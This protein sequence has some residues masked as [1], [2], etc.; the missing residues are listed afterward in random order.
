MLI[1][2]GIVHTM[3]GPVI[4]NGYVEV[5]GRKIKAVGPMSDL[6]A[7]RSAPVFDAEGGH[8]IPG[9][10]D[11][12]CHLGMFGNGLGFE[13]DDGNESTDPCT[14]QLRAVDAINPQDR[15]FREAREGGITT[16]LTGPGSANPIAGQ[17]AAIKTDGRWVDEMVLKAPIAMKLMPAASP[18]RCALRIKSSIGASTLRQLSVP[19]GGP[20]RLT[21]LQRRI[22]DRRLSIK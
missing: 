13:G 11:A 5:E 17:F 9:M 7:V 22:C 3:S 14:P 19:K 15:C 4:P 20:R 18:A 16:V 8:I 6:G 2:N 12:H 10:I 21:G 1:I